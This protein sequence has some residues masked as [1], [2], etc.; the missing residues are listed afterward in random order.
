MTSPR[1]QLPRRLPTAPAREALRRFARCHG[2]RID[3]LADVLSMPPA[4]VE[5]VMG[6]RWLAWEDADIV[7]I[8]LR[9]HPYELWPDWFGPLSANA[10]S[11]TRPSTIAED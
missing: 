5:S 10:A 4:L 1:W 11:V 8:S 3:D 6:A 9:T 7:A 2:N